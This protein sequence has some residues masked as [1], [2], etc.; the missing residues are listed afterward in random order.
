MAG[1]MYTRKSSKKFF[2][3]SVKIIVKNVAE[4]Y[5]KNTHRKGP[6]KVSAKNIHQNVL[7][8]VPNKSQGMHPYSYRCP[9]KK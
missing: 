3:K 6:Q 9:H 4:K 1:K 8:K 5:A 2:H 7:K